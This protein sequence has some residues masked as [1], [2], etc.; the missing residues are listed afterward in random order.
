M[1]AEHTIETLGGPAGTVEDLPV[2]QPDGPRPARRRVQVSIEVAVSLRSRVVEQAAVELDD[3]AT[4]V[5][6]VAVDGAARNRS[7]T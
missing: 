7:N 4:E 5:E 6:D 2:R 3:N 1:Q